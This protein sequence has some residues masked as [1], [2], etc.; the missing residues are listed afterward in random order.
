MEQMEKALLRNQ[1]R[2][3]PD[4][5]KPV[6]ITSVSDIK[7]ILVELDP[8]T[9]KT[10]AEIPISTMLNEVEGGKN[11]TYSVRSVT[12]SKSKRDILLDG[13]SLIKKREEVSNDIIESTEEIEIDGKKV[14]PAILKSN[15]EG[16]TW[17]DPLIKQ[18]TG[19]RREGTLIVWDMND[20]YQY[21]YEIFAHKLTRIC[22]TE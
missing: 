2:L 17:V 4:I 6:E 3:D 16:H 7:R 19:G 22:R 13:L 8:N 1:Q 14:K 9:N 21:R 15:I 11:V 10:H 18:W 12:K 5:L 20:G